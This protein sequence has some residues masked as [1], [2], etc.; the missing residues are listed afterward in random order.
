M[1]APRAG[2]PRGGGG[3]LGRP[4]RL[5]LPR[6]GG[7]LLDRDRHRRRCFRSKCRSAAA[8]SAPSSSAPSSTGSS[9]PRRPRVGSRWR[10]EL[11]E[12]LEVFRR[13]NYERIYLR[14]ASVAQGNAVV[15]VLR[16]L[17]EHFADRPNAIPA[18]RESGVPAGSEAARPDR[19]HICGGDDR[20]LRDGDGRIRAR[21][22]C[23]QAAAWRGGLAQEVIRISGIGRKYP[24]SV[25]RPTGAASADGELASVDPGGT[26]RVEL[27]GKLAKALVR[28]R[29]RGRRYRREHRRLRLGGPLARAGASPEAERRGSWPV[30]RR[31]RRR[32]TRN[33][34]PSS[35]VNHDMF[36]MT[37]RTGSFSVRAASAERWATLAPR[38]GGW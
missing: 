7:R 2:D 4:D 17:V 19:G 21:M 36:S 11:A 18:V 37:P 30:P 35:P 24:G 16:A 6:L 26:E 32:T 15:E 38:A 8:T 34:W 5:C 28:P 33:A 29:R 12:A 10:A 27:F 9:P 25:G 3:E 20:P 23:R 14:P 13:V 31:H 1:V 22:G